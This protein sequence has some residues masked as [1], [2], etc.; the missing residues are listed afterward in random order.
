MT[1]TSSIRGIGGFVT[2]R[3]WSA[4]SEKL[5]LAGLLCALIP[6]AACQANRPTDLETLIAEEAKKLTIAG[7]DLKNPVPDDAQSIALGKEHFQHH[8]QI[9]HGMDG[10]GTGVPFAG[11]MSPPVANLSDKDVQEYTDGQLK[12]IIQNGIRFT[13]MPGFQGVLDEDEMWYLVRFLRHLPPPGSEGIPAVY[14]EEQ[15]EHQEAEQKSGA[16][17]GAHKHSHGEKHEH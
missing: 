6:L 15:E 3:N 4:L 2:P 11:K 12:L 16:K 9:C 10:H 7:K 13:G 1:G 17:P 5:A 14:R 8:C